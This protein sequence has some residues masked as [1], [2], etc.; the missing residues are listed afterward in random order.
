MRS[1]RVILILVFSFCITVC[2]AEENKVICNILSD[3]KNEVASVLLLESENGEEMS[4][5]DIIV[6]LKNTVAECAD[7]GFDSIVV[8]V[9]DKLV[10][11]DNIVEIIDGIDVVCV[12]ECDELK[13]ARMIGD[14]TVIYTTDKSPEVNDATNT[15][16]ENEKSPSETLNSMVLMSIVLIAVA[17]IVLLVLKKKMGK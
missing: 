14:T 5:S 15:E 2:S 11:V 1:L 12:M 16:K 13:A 17:L 3:D 9:S 4:E 10:S 7:E 8:T 6:Y